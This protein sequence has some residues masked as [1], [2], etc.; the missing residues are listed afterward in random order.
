MSGHIIFVISKPVISDRV[1][2]CGLSSQIFLSHQS[3]TDVTNLYSLVKRLLCVSSLFRVISQKS[4]FEIQFIE[5]I[6]Q[7]KKYIISKEVFLY[8][9]YLLEVLSM[10]RLVA[11]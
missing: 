7:F 1:E 8:E 10:V 9:M 3:V 4:G 11:I 6:I 2:G 5:I